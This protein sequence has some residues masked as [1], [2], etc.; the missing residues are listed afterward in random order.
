MGLIIYTVNV[1]SYA[2]AYAGICSGS[3]NASDD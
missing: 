1:G 3:Y 2:G